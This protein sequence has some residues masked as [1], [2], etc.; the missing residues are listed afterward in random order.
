MSSTA[1]YPGDLERGCRSR[2]SRSRAPWPRPGRLRP[3]RNAAPERRPTIES[4]A[5][6][7]TRRSL[8]PR[9]ESP[10]PWSQHAPARTVRTL[11]SRA[12]RSIPSGRAFGRGQRRSSPRRRTVPAVPRRR[13]GRRRVRVRPVDD[14]AE[15]LLG[16]APRG[17]LKLVGEHAAVG[18]RGDVVTFVGWSVEPAGDGVQALSVQLSRTSSTKQRPG[19]RATDYNSAAKSWLPACRRLSVPKNAWRR[20]S[21]LNRLAGGVRPS[22]SA[23]LRMWCGAAPQQTPR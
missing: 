7:S 1:G 9:P 18:R 15:A 22:A 19:R 11:C 21:A 10:L 23:T 8:P 4:D 13:S 16:P 5:H 12:V 2:C 17:S 14:V 20:M 3:I 6:I